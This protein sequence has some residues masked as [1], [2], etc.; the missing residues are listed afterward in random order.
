LPE[1]RCW[2]GA[3]RAKW[4]SIPVPLSPES[5]RHSRLPLW[6]DS[7]VGVEPA[8]V[9]ETSYTRIRFTFRDRDGLVVLND[10]I[11]FDGATQ[12]VVPEAGGV[13]EDGDL[14]PSW[15]RA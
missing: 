11:T 7:V 2:F 14:A 9:S 15:R 12:I 4:Q 8:F 3:W 13:P 5:E 10:Y 1:L 6:I